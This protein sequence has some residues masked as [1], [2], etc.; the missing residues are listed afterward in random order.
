MYN[1][2][3]Y[4]AGFLI[5]AVFL[6]PLVAVLVIKLGFLLLGHLIATSPAV[7]PARLARSRPEGQCEE[8]Y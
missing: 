2:W 5:L 7:R 1:Y 8:S 6:I 4:F 3:D